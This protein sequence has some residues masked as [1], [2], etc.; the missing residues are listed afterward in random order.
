[1]PLKRYPALIRL[2]RKAA[3]KKPLGDIWPLVIVNTLTLVIGR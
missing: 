1:M 2:L 3:M